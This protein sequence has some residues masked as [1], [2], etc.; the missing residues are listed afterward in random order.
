MDEPQEPE[1]PALETVIV[2]HTQIRDL[3]VGL[4]EVMQAALAPTVEGALEE[5]STIVNAMMEIARDEARQEGRRE[6]VEY[7]L[8]RYGLV[9]DDN[10]DPSDNVTERLRA[11]RLAGMLDAI[12]IVSRSAYVNNGMAWFEVNPAELE[13][14][15]RELGA[16]VRWAEAA[17]SVLDLRSSL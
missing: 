4:A 16:D 3:L 10:L 14:R 1:E 2:G 6:V 12:G 11:N 5:L 15:L 9:L 7:A 8:E 13:P 17:R